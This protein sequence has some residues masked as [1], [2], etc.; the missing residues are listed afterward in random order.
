MRLFAHNRGRTEERVAGC[1]P[2]RLTAVREA[3]PSWQAPVMHWPRPVPNIAQHALNPRQ[4]RAA[5]PVTGR[6]PTGAR[7]AGPWCDPLDDP[8]RSLAWRLLPDPG[9]RHQGL[10]RDGQ[11][12]DD[13]ENALHFVV[14]HCYSLWDVARGQDRHMRS[15]G[16]SNASYRFRADAGN[17]RWRGVVQSLWRRRMRLGLRSPSAAPP[18]RAP[19][20]DAA[21]SAAV[22]DGG[23]GTPAI[24][25]RATR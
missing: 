9:Q 7:G 6:C 1:I 15:I 8:R 23:S 14:T 12:R 25:G 19:R 5:R 13:E 11:C 3:L 20:H 17:G 22:P 18:S 16:R 21:S 24:R 10:S 4:C 2:S